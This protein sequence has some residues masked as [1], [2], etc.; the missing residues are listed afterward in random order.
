[1]STP[2]TPRLVV[3]TLV[4]AGRRSPSRDPEPEDGKGD[5]TRH[6]RDVTGYGTGPSGGGREFLRPNAQTGSRSGE[7]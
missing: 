5:G 7:S 3:V 1:M 6:G 2:L 4:P